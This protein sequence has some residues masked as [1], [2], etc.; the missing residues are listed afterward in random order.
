M[1]IAVMRNLV[2]CLAMAGMAVAH[3]DGN[4]LPFSTDFE[5]GVD[6]WL[7]GDIYAEEPSRVPG[8]RFGG[9]A[10]EQTSGGAIRSAFVWDALETNTAYTLSFFLRGSGGGKVKVSVINENWTW[11]GASG[12]VVEPEWR[13]LAF[14][15]RT[16]PVKRG[17]TFYIHLSFAGEGRVLY[18]GFRL[19]K[20]TAASPYEPPAIQFSC[21]LGEPGEIHFEEDGV[22]TMVARAAVADAAG[23]LSV[24]I[25]DARGVVVASAAMPPA[26]D[27]RIPLPGCA[28]S[29]YYPLR[30]ELAGT[31]GKARV[32]REAAFVVTRRAGGNPFFGMSSATGVGAAALRRV[33]FEWVRGN[34]K[35]WQWEE[36]DAPREFTG[37][38]PVE[39]RRPNAFR[40]LATTGGVAPAWARAK[41]R[42]IW[43]E[44]PRKAL[45]FFR[46]LV[47]TTRDV[48]DQYE[49]I[50]EPDL[51]LPR[52]KGVT[53]QQAISHYCDILQ[54]V[55]PVIREGGRP[56]VIDVSGVSE[57]RDFIEGVLS[58]TP[59]SVDIVSLHPYSWPR[60]L[61]D[62]G[63]TVSTPETGGFLDNLRLSLSMLSRHPRKRVVI[64]EL[65]W[66]LAM[67]ASLSGRASAKL[68]W[69]LARMY[70]LARSFPDIEY[71]V[72]FSLGNT[73]ERGKNDYCVWR[74]T[75]EEGARPTSAVAAAC[76]AARQLP[77][78]SGGAVSRVKE[79]GVFLTR[80]KREG[81]MR[82]AFWTD[83]PSFSRE[84]GDLSGRSVSARSAFGERLAP[85][86]L[87]F[88]EAP[89]Y[90]EVDAAEADAFETALGERLDALY[91]TRTRPKREEAVATRI[92]AADWRTF[93][94]LKSPYLA[95]LDRRMDV[96]PPDPT[97]QWDGPQDLS[98]SYLL[99]WDDANFYFFAVVADD[100]HH[101]P[102]TGRDIFKN[103]AVQIAFDTLDDAQ[104]GAGYSEDDY[105]IGLS[106]GHPAWRWHGGGVKQGPIPEVECSVIRTDGQTEY[107]AAVPWTALG[108]SAA[109]KTLGLAF[110]V[111]DNDDG[112]TARY[113]LVF[114]G[115]IA[116]GKNPC[117][118]KHLSLRSASSIR[119]EQSGK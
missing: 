79:K 75:P 87:V 29:G 16:P 107:R 40:R 106:A 47:R 41:G 105:E 46:H 90:I 81:R 64:G 95:T 26:M 45:P 86:K 99:G 6:G 61:A 14:T 116:D 21:G 24:R 72:W 78:P 22:P 17:R 25:V 96:I 34:T 4:L 32:T 56:V 28:G 53:F 55:A 76:E 112:G 48:V 110:I 101:V 115:G 103:D 117:K 27:V 77:F 38:E 2:F 114:G 100:T 8:G 10:M 91:A 51:A 111:Q 119:N 18:D 118:F 92:S 102:C 5:T 31:D 54:T 52:E 73:P 13:R 113:R 57:G 23:L 35:F 60:E 44:D 39:K 15:F 58:R 9:Y 37:D 50:N 66:A 1:S 20:G 85:C 30:A 71:L 89:V 68:G 65:G 104:S 42:A 93:D 97:V 49:I 69:Y 88:S 74:V 19:E 59:E 62:D 67:D 11:L 108:L 94:F 33:G 36:R 84:L 12:K 109:P 7:G 70:V 98:A 82:F 80:W 63:R 43:C 3:A 83:E